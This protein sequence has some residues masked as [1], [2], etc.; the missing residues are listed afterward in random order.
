METLL[1]SMTARQAAVKNINRL[2]RASREELKGV[3]FRLLIL[4]LVLFAYFPPA[5]WKL[6]EK[7]TTKPLIKPTSS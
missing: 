4:M 1:G 6:E 3:H 5:F 2:P 7:I